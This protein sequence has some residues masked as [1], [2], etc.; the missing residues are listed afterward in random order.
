MLTTNKDA[1]RDASDEDG[2]ALPCAQK[3]L[4]E[5]VVAFCVDEIPEDYRLRLGGAEPAPCVGY[6]AMHCRTSFGIDLVKDV[7]DCA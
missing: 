7:T 3:V 5:Y 1:S 6:G 2:D 4:L